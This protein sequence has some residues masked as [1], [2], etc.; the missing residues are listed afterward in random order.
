MSESYREFMNTCE[1][2]HAYWYGFTD[3]IAWSRNPREVLEQECLDEPHYYR[4]GYLIGK[5]CQALLYGSVGALVMKVI[6]L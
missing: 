3:S 4:F 6:M 1:E 2:I 5:I